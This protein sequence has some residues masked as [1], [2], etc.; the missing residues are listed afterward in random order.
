MS[1]HWKTEDFKITVI[2]AFGLEKEFGG[3]AAQ[4]ILSNTQ[5]V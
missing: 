5:K 2:Y 3:Q 4:K 1:W